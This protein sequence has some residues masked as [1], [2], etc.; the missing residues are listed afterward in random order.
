[1]TADG[2]A[3]PTGATVTVADLDRYGFPALLAVLARRRRAIALVVAAAVAAGI[4]LCLVLPRQFRAETTILPSL[5][6][7]S[8]S[9]A[10]SVAALRSAAGAMGVSVGVGAQDPSVLFPQVLR[11]RTLAE[12]VLLREYPVRGGGTRRLLDALGKAG[13]DS[14]L[15][16]DAAVRR[17]RGRVL[18]LRLDAKSGVTAVSVELQDAALSAAVANACVEELDRFNREVKNAQAGKQVDFISN[19]LVEVEQQ[20][21][22]AEDAL[23]QFREQNRQLSG[24]PQLLLQEARLARD[25]QLNEQ[26]FLTLKTQLEVARIEEVKNVPLVVVLDRATPPV[27]PS[28]PQRL[29]LLAC[30]GGLGLALGI[31]LALC[32]AWLEIASEQPPV[33]ALREIFR[34]D[35]AL[36]ARGRRHDL[37]TP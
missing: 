3:R 26:L 18:R 19:R 13:S 6:V 24:S 2:G 27:R 14:S 29:Q 28:S 33:R 1:M 8:D 21:A 7:A 10:A 20:L 15:R 32:Q 9:D 16:L 4:V 25:V 22:A 35:T 12:R 37:P 34:N 17:W 31:A 36:L 23:K 5:R 30:A 11:S